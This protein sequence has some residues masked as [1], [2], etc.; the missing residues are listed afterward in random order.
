MGAF[1][2]AVSLTLSRYI[3]CQ[4]SWNTYRSDYG[5]H[6]SLK[7]CLFGLEDQ[8]RASIRVPHGDQIAED[9]SQSA[10]WFE[11]EE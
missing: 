1:W 5:L 11:T 6:L 4:Y 8:S 3:D 10:T 9:S 7:I 2:M